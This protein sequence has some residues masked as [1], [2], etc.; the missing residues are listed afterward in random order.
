M[1][2]RLIKGLLACA[3]VVCA[4]SGHSAT[5]VP[6]AEPVGYLTL[7]I[8]P[9]QSAG[10]K[11]EVVEFFTYACPICFSYEPAL[12]AW[13][14]QNSGR[15]VFMRVPVSLRHDW[16]PVQKLYFALEL[17]GQSE[18][19]HSRVFD[20]IHKERRSIKSDEA[21]GNLAEYL[22]LNRKQ[23]DAVYFSSEIQEKIKTAAQMQL[24]YQIDQV[25]MVAV[26]GRYLTSPAKV[27]DMVGDDKPIA[28][29]EALSLRILDDLLVK[30]KKANPAN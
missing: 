10:S 7:N 5:A 22:G 25:P 12:S 4:L 21:I 16:L 29:L 17:L 1:L 3:A 27:A 19:L 6:G 18:A 14:A 24:A 9:A 23:F 11:V 15:I 26:E 2:T 20:A 8:S 13:A 30:S 28:E